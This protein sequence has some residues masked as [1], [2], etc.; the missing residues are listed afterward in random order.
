MYLIHGTTYDYIKEIL[1][2]NVLLSSKITGNLN[3]GSGI[4][5]SNPFVFMG[6][7]PNMPDNK[8]FGEV[9]IYLDPSILYNRVFFINNEHVSDPEKSG[10]KYKR[11]NKNINKILNDTYKKSLKLPDRKAFQIFQQIAIKNKINIA[12]YILAI[13]YPRENKIDFFKK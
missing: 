2:T 3:E 11:Y 8:L 10:K 4:Y 12:K 6:T 7:T 5:T 13:Y 9:F 1:K